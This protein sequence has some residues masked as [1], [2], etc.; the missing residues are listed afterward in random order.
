MAVP[1]RCPLLLFVS[2]IYFSI[3]EFRVACGV[4][5]D[6]LLESLHVSRITEW[7]L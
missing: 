6:H 5:G 4:M 3:F 2:V 7:T 1:E